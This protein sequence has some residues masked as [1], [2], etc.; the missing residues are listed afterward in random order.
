MDTSISRSAEDTR[1]LGRAWAVSATA[2]WVIALT[3]DLGSGKTELVKGFAVGLGVSARVH[4]PTFALIHEHQ[5]TRL[6]L[7]HLDLYRLETAEAILRSGL[8]EYLVQPAGVSIVEWAERWFEAAPG[9]PQ[10]P[11]RLRR[12]WFE[13]TGQFERRI[14]YEDIGA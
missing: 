9:C 2:G 3:G 5:G 13:T 10:L 11:G 6:T 7:H 1:A 8:E 12:V 14:R 4:S